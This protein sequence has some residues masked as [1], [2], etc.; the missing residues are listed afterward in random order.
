MRAPGKGLRAVE[1]NGNGGGGTALFDNAIVT[2]LE[3]GRV[4][5]KIDKLAAEG[6][7][8][9]ARTSQK[10]TASFIFND[11]APAVVRASGALTPFGGQ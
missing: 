7:E 3:D 11:L 4:E 1:G 2:I 8:L 9:I 6:D 5:A 10:K